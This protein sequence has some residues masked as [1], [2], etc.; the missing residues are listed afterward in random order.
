MPLKITKSFPRPKGKLLTIKYGGTEHDIL[1]TYHSIER[2]TK[3]NLRLEEVA[4]CLLNPDEVLKGH[5][6]RFIAHK[7][8]GNHLI[9]A[10]CEYDG[11]LPLLITVYYPY[12]KRYYRGGG[13]YEDKIF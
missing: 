2:C 11:D 8:S 10:V 3:W 4:E 12:S 7:L 9:R 1:F 13:V 6:G 5:L